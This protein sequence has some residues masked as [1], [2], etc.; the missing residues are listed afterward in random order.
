MYVYL[1]QMLPTYSC[2]GLLNCRANSKGRIS[3][4]VFQFIEGESTA[5]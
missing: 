5:G 3:R 1:I 2:D 4:Y